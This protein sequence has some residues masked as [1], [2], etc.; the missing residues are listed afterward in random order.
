MMDS[1]NESPL[2][3]SNI[4]ANNPGNTSHRL[5][6]HIIIAADERGKET[7]WNILKKLSPALANFDLITRLLR[8][9]TQIEKSQLFQP[10]TVGK[11][12]QENVLNPFLEHCD[13]AIEHLEAEERSF[14]GDGRLLELDPQGQCGIAVQHVSHQLVCF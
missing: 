3:L 4:I 9:D 6:S 10:N 1:L 13:A 7:C 12:I 8:D 11:E 2:A 5:L 14:S